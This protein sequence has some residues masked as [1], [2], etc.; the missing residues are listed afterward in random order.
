ML[1]CARTRP[2]HEA[3]L[4]T[5]QCPPR[6]HARLPR[7]HGH[8]WWTQSPVEPPAQGP[9]APHARDLQE[10]ES[11]GLPLPLAPRAGKP[12][13]FGAERRL[14]KHDEFVRAQRKGRRVNTPHFALLIS[15]REAADAPSPAPAR[16]GL[17][18]S[19]KVGGAVQR[20]R[21]KRVCRE[22]FRAWPDLL[23]AGIDL[24]VI[25]RP[26]AETLPL[27]GVRSEWQGVASLLRKRAAEAL[28][29]SRDRHH[30][31]GTAGRPKGPSA[32]R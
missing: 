17:V 5:S 26:G 9:Q 14:R 7:S 6:P 29:H 16:M 24:V 1:S 2:Y 25:A 21:V 8:Q 12:L 15:A 3:H 22:C 4:P 10:V 18:V 20:N 30:V 31:A 11:S 28:A 19:R 23:P 27:A 32:P 13:A